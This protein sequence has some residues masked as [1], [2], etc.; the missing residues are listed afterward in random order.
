MDP[1]GTD[2]AELTRLITLALAVHWTSNV[3]ESSFGDVFA[4]AD[5]FAAYIDNGLTPE[6]D[7]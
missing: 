4:I 1:D 7:E 6:V 5:R 3:A 2:D